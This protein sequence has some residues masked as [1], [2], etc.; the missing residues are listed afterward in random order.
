MYNKPYH[1]KRRRGQIGRQMLLGG[2]VSYR[3]CFA[4]IEVAYVDWLEVHTPDLREDER[5]V[6]VRL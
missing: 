1:K 6:D 2:H 4:C 5:Q 3:E